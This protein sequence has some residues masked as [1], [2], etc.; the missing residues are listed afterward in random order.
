M[1]VTVYTS[2]T[3]HVEKVEVTP[4]NATKAFFSVYYYMAFL[5]FIYLMV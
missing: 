3:V 4:E 1:T 2:H 5:R